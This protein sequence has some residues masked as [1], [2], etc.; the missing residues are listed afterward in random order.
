MVTTRSA[1]GEA[2]RFSAYQ[3]RPASLVYSD[4][5]WANKNL[6]KAQRQANAYMDYDQPPA[7]V[8]RGRGALCRG[9]GPGSSEAAD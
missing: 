7:A 6:G 3:H 2:L 8:R 5:Q 4:E 9:H 1:K